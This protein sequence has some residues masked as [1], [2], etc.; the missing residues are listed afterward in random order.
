MPTV[1]ANHRRWPFAFL[2]VI[3]AL[4]GLIATSA[5]APYGAWPMA[6]VA[7]A[8]LTWTVRAASGLRAALAL[9]WFFGLTFMGT[10]LHWQTSIMTASYLG[11]TLVT[12]LLYLAIGAG[13]ALTRQLPLWPL[14]AA[15]IWTSGEAILA[16]WPFD[17]FMWMRLGYAAVDSP[18]A[19]Y[20]PF[21]GAAFASFVLAG[22]GALVAS[23]LEVRTVRRVGGVTASIVGTLAVGLAGIGWM[24]PDTSAGTI[25]VGWVQGGAPGGGIYGLGPA[26]TITRN[27]AEETASLLE[28]VAAGEYP[29]PAF[30]VWPE[31]STDL[32]PRSDGP[33]RAL[34]DSTVAAA[35]RPILV[36]AV[37]LGPGLDERQTVSVWWTPEGPQEI[38]EKR[39]LVP[40]GEWI[41][42][43][44]VLLPLI[45]P[46]RYVGAQGV[47]GT[48][49]GVIQAPLGEGRSLRLGV[50]ICYE[51]IYPPT[52]VEASTG[53]DLLTVVSSN[54]MYQGTAQIDQQFAAT[55]VRAAEMR[56]DILVVTTS[57]VSGRIGPRG[58]TLWTAPDSVSASGVENMP[59][60]H[61]VT[62]AMTLAGPAE[63]GLAGLGLVGVG[64]GLIRKVRVRRGGRMDT[65][66]S[67]TP[68]AGEE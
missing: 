40:F 4:G 33:T 15:A 11:L 44:S 20:Y 17:G 62:P 25:N 2:A 8:A 61:P 14:W 58:E 30:I 54:A 37:Y 48:Q 65:D 5:F 21:L 64:L 6:I 50:A 13:L 26:R 66:V 36:G 23:T 9:G 22:M 56:R 19:G 24:P 27:Q 38:Y 34:V 29:E 45:P 46:L 51:V 67:G 32:D 52:L 49:P 53:A 16:V 1:T 68:R 39:N 35:D 28:A 10:S 60:G 18:V 41:P 42:L 55:R 7:V 57:G 59:L 3:V 47:P 12:S 43:R 63:A 31:N